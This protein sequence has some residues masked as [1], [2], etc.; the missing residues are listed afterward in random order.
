MEANVPAFRLIARGCRIKRASPFSREDNP[1]NPR[2]LSRRTALK[3]ASCGFG[4]LA[5][6]GLSSMEARAASSDS[7]LARKAPHFPARARRVIFLCMNGAP[8][9][10][11]TFDY[12]PAL[13]LA[14][15]RSS[16]RPGRI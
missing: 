12:K 11:D 15:G 3:S 6:A 10:V 4:Y 8:S 14:D 1:M 7:P 9:H 5:F 13:S 2:R 16:D